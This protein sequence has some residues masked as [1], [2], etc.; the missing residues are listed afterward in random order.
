MIPPFQVIEFSKMTKKQAQEHFD[1]FVNEIPV[2][3]KLLLGA[4]KA[5]GVKNIEQFDIS[6]ESLPLLWAWLKERITTAPKSQEEIKELHSTLPNW[7]LEDISDWKLD[8]GTLTMAV[9]VSLYF[10]EVF[11]KE[12]PHLHWGFKNKPK[13]DID[14]NK[15]VI[16]GFKGGALNPPTVV[17]NLCRSH[18]KGKVDKDLLSLFEVWRRFI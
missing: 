5:S 18:V 4:I 3:I 2:R 15:P 6:P 16:I 13:S 11:L 10:A 17:I 9:D 1:W 14:V 12:F 7:V 8:S